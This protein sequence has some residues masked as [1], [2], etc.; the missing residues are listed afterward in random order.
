MNTLLP[1]NILRLMSK[2]DRKALKQKTAEEKSATAEDKS[3]KELQD[4]VTALLRRREIPFIHASMMKRSTLP[5]GW[6]DYSFARR[7]VPMCFECKTER[8]KLTKEQEVMHRRLKSQGWVVLVIRSLKE[9]QDAL[10][11]CE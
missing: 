4:Q 6:P 5:I 7:G 9:A 2:E 8:G 10:E 1:D 3:E 11:D